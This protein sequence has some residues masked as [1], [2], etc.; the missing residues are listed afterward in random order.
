MEQQWEPLV[1]R[2]PQANEQKHHAPAHKKFKKLDSD[3]VEAPKPISL[4]SAKQIQQA[5]CSK[6]LTREQLAQRLNVKEAVIRD[7]ENGKAVP[8]RSVVNKINR[9][10]GVKIEL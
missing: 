1:F 7:Y 10:L 5:R 2:K 8:E 4:S 9:I 6:N 3:D